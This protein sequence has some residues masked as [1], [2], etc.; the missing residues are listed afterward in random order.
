MP[1]EVTTRANG[2]RRAISVCIAT[3]RP[4]TIGTAIESIRRQTWRDWELLVVG[5]GADPKVS[6]VATKAANGDGRVRYLDISKRGLSAA[7]NA[8]LAAARNEIVAMMDDDCEARPD[9]L[10][11]LVQCF[12]EKPETGLVGGS[13]LAGPPSWRTR[14]TCLSLVATEAFYDPASA[15]PPPGFEWFGANFAV[16]RSVAEL[17]GPFD[18]FF[19]A[20]ATFR[21]C[22]DVDYKLRLEAA[23]VKM[24]STP[25]S[26]VFHTYGRRYGAR[27]VVRYWDGHGL[28]AGAIAAKLTL[29]GD[30]RGRDSL[31]RAAREYTVGSLQ[32]RSPHEILRNAVRLQSFLRGYGWCLRDFEVDGRGLLVPRRR[33]SANG[34]W[35]A[36]GSASRQEDRQR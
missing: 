17:V 29:V 14:S 3:V 35:D 28:G 21:S 25:R 33:A 34:S 32:R 1:D 13:F 12:E 15:P 2:G 7:R 8:G 22:E 16:R 23:G 24:W 19:G 18:E 20:G 26:V 31:R 5:Q 6:A 10:A 4:S 11:A 9:W 36:A 30:P 27:A